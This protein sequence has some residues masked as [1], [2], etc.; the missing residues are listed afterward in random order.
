MLEV[1]LLL[2]AAAKV[3]RMVLKCFWA[4][5]AARCSENA[6][7]LGVDPKLGSSE[8]SLAL[9]N[10]ASYMAEHLRENQERCQS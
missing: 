7:A 3:R 2:N 6:E 8:V 4:S 10:L 5:L 9:L 1:A